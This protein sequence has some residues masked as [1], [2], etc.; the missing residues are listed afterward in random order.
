MSRDGGWGSKRRP[1]KFFGAWAWAWGLGLRVA[2]IGERGNARMRTKRQE[3]RERMK[4]TPRN[5]NPNWSCISCSAAQT[6][7]AKPWTCLQSSSQFS[8][9]LVFGLR[10]GPLRLPR[11]RRPGECSAIMPG[12]GSNSGSSSDSANSAYTS[13]RG[14]EAGPLSDSSFCIIEGRDTV[15]D[16]APMQ[17]QEIREHI[18]MRRNKIFLLMEEVRR[19][20]I[21]QK[22]KSAEQGTALE[23]EE[24][25]DVP[26]FPSSIPFLPPLVRT[27]GKISWQLS[28]IL[29]PLSEPVNVETSATLKQYYATCFA[30][31]SSI[32]LFAGLLSP[33]LELKLGIGGT[34]YEDFIRGMHLPLQLSE[35]DPIVASF[36][37]GAV[38]VIT[39]LMVVEINNVKQQEQKRC[40]YCH[41]TGYLACARCSGSGAL[42]VKESLVSAGGH[43][44]SGLRMPTSQRCSTCAGAAKVMCPTC[45]CTGMELAS[46]HDPRI[47]PFD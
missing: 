42:I 7:R 10:S 14:D 46:E 31:I 25:D 39:S 32:M 23:E 2:I 4:H 19:L 37:G 44:D 20:R 13:A 41:G 21:Q 30:L 28:A 45:L 6:L 11:F 35:V 22:I 18:N 24:E 17:L 47:D 34:S 9:S 33:I 36:S 27:Y 5:R 38:G 8:Q 15:L 16:F 12:S 29:N 40:R 1:P 3:R 43:A 26:E